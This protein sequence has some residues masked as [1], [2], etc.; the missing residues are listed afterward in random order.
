MIKYFN[1]KALCLYAMLSYLLYPN[2]SFCQ[3]VNYIR[4]D[5][6]NLVPLTSYIKNS[7][8]VLLPKYP[9]YINNIKESVVVIDNKSNIDLSKS[10]SI[11]GVDI[12]NSKDHINLTAK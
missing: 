1:I 11:R 6:T 3:D 2:Y 5:K 4:H 12:I 8:K 7:K 9:N 10:T